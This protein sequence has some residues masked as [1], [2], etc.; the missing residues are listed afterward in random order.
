[1]MQ[2]VAFSTRSE[3]LFTE[4]ATGAAMAADVDDLDDQLTV[5]CNLA[6][7]GA[8]ASYD[9]RTANYFTLIETAGARAAEIM[10]QLRELDPPRPSEVKQATVVALPRVQEAIAAPTD[11][12]RPASSFRRRATAAR[13]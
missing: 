10:R 5:I 6:T 9:A 13:T 2:R 7:L 12:R 8:D 11:L 1:M 4:E 3:D